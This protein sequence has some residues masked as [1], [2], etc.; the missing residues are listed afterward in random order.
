MLEFSVQ[1][2][3]I[4]EKYILSLDFHYF[5]LYAGLAIDWISR[6]M[7]ITDPGREVIEV[8]GLDTKM[9]SGEMYN[10]YVAWGG[11]VVAQLV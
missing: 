8:I 11:D 1:A 5:H 3:I 6:N 9:R 4:I 10:S 2:S 7:Y